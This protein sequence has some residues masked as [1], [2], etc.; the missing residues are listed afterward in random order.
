MSG[1]ITNVTPGSGAS[2]FPLLNDVGGML[3]TRRD[4]VPVT[5][6]FRSDNLSETDVTALF[7]ESY[8][9]HAAGRHFAGEPFAGERN[10]RVYR[11]K[12]PTG[13]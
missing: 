1:L 2:V 3:L 10:V 13:V 7:G 12:Q 4:T 6:K 5:Y 11:Q 8:P 9:T